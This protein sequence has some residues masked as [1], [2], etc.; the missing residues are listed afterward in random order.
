M[1]VAASLL[2]WSGVGL[3]TLNHQDMSEHPEP[4]TVAQTWPPLAPLGIRLGRDHGPR[5]LGVTKK[6]GLGLEAN[7][8]VVS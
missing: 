1:K 3:V 6:P 7:W 5:E 8:S 2:W 4:A